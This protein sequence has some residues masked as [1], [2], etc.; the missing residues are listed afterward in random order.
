MK[1]IRRSS[2]ANKV[3]L[4]TL[5][6]NLGLACNSAYADATADCIRF[7]AVKEWQAAVTL[8]GDGE[9]SPFPNMTV[10]NHETLTAS[11]PLKLDN[12]SSS[13][14]SN[15][16]F[17]TDPLQI[18]DIKAMIDYKTV[19]KVPDVPGCESSTI[20]TSN[21][22][23]VTE[24]EGGLDLQFSSGTYSLKLAYLAPYRLATR[25]CTG[26]GHES[27][28]NLSRGLFN[29]N[30]TQLV[31]NQPL[32]VSGL[33]L[34]GQ[35]KLTEPQ[36]IA[37]GLP[38]TYTVTWNIVPKNGQGP[39]KKETITR[40]CK[41]S[42]SIIGCENQ[43]L[44]EVIDIAGTAFTLH[45]QSDRAAGRNLVN[46][47]S[48]AHAQA[49][50]GWTLSVHHRYDPTT[51]E[52]YLGDGDHRDA[53][54]LGTVKSSAAGGF[55]IASE[56][57]GIVYE[58]GS[59]GRHLKTLN[60]FTGATLLTFGY[61]AKKTLINIRDSSGNHTVIQRDSNSRPTSIVGPYGQTTQLTVDA[62]G[63]LASI[64]HPSGMVDKFTTTPEGLLTSHT[65][66]R[67]KTSKFSYDDLGRLKS[68]T[69][70]ARAKQTLTRSETAS[71]FDVTLRT[72]EGRTTLYQTTPSGSGGETRVITDGVGLKSQISHSADGTVTTAL[73]NGIQTTRT[74]EP[75]PRFGQSAAGIKNSSITMPSGLKLTGT[76]ARSVTLSHSTDPFSLSALTH[77]VSINGRTYSSEYNGSSRI[78]VNKTPTGRTRQTVIDPQGRV[79]SRETTGLFPTAYTYDAHGRLFTVTQGNGVDARTVQFS[80][81][82]GGYLEGVTDPLGR[83]VTFVRDVMGRLTQQA[84]P[85]GR[86]IS[87]SYD[88]NGN[89]TALTP[90]GRPAH[91]F[92]YSSIERVASYV[93]PKVGGVAT[94]TKYIYNRDQQLVS[95]SQPG[96]NR[97]A[98]G[99]DTAGRATTLTILRGTFDFSYD[100]NTGRLSSIT[101][102]DGIGLTYA[103]DGDLVT[104]S[105]LTGAVTGSVQ[106]TYD[107]DFRL[108]ELKV[109]NTN[110]I[111][112]Q[113]DHDG[114]LTNAGALTLLRDSKNGLLTGTTLGKV[115]DSFSVDG[116]GAVNMYTARFN[117]AD[118]LKAQYRYDKLGR[119]TTRIETIGGTTDTFIYSYDP[120]GRLATVEK[121]GVNQ[122]VYTYE[123]NGNRVT[124]TAV[125]AT[126]YGSYD[127]QDRLTRYGTASYSY[128]ANGE[129][130]SKTDGTQKTNFTYDALGNLL[131]V[132]LPDNRKIEY[133]V[134]GRN[135]RIGK[136]ING[137]KVQG[138]LYQSS[139][140]PA[141]ELDGNNNVVSRF[142]YATRINVPE[143]M[144]KD[145]VTYR[146]ITDH[147]GSPRL[148]LNTTTGQI[149]QRMDYDEFGN[150]TTDTN[151][152]FQPFGFA[153]GLYD[154]DT[155]LVRFGAR[156][157]DAETGR[158]TVKDPIGFNGGSNMYAY[159]QND[160]VNRRDPLG[161]ADVFFFS[162][163]TV[164]GPTPVSPEAEVVL[165]SGYSTESGTYSGV[166]G[167]RGIK[168]GGNA[169][170]FAYLEG[171]ESYLNTGEV[172]HISMAEYG[173]GAEELLFG[174]GICVGVYQAGPDKSGK[175]EEGFFIGVG[176]G[177]VGEHGTV[178]IGFGF[179]LVGI[180]TDWFQGLDREIRNIYGVP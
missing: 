104:A 37:F 156:D 50:G 89:L 175:Y 121:N 15:M 39:K 19:I 161:L 57:G 105:M 4:V 96:G 124:R 76:S 129:L 73:P 159:V 139:L 56:A 138:F 90:P 77:T 28:E 81:D 130:Q 45:Y 119:I 149:G 172:E 118:V 142:I 102:P 155:K 21:G 101:A 75:D 113:F 98:L 2:L 164:G 162:A 99:Y 11:F 42:G 17:L 70:A 111:A 66:V 107:N 160:P 94:N 16:R 30:G 93:A 122:S 140:R 166:I 5:M 78:F 71:A 65:N 61:D 43:S 18:K 33:T 62:S 9:G 48:V 59:D 169:N 143:Y 153:G 128:T 72:A 60:S 176:G 52:L 127:F 151:P 14:P 87:Y 34:S 108:T 74:L 168:V 46:S 20:I 103:Y 100:P 158:W 97:I 49:L 95:I 125:S 54:D 38:M 136:K 27:A 134:D 1:I 144:I 126:I 171:F 132:V 41:Q 68:N 7:S 154:G 178:G 24:A 29:P 109:N 64:K 92:T 91:R 167:A 69:N 63:Y 135:R 147:L 40:P 3:F 110:S 150:V 131:R 174:E 80:Y 173:F 106:R 88:V 13:C 31:G 86:T 179:P 120:V 6:L 10:S 53:M 36:N 47:V 146:I 170:Y 25:D 85:D 79:I 133:L 84:L 152:G 55:W 137:L 8:R 116:F 165:I 115:T 51:N 26:D 44:G 177:V 163:V 67:K 83:N 141:A 114:L 32:P 145:G 58:F 35:A 22:K 112:F 23:P 157:Y 117:T 148:V 123:A 12:A 180:V 82:Q